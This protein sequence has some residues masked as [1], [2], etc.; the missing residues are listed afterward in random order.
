MEVERQKK[1]TNAT[2]QDYVKENSHYKIIENMLQHGPIPL[3]LIVS[4]LK[5]MGIHTVSGSTTSTSFQVQNHTKTMKM[6][7]QMRRLGFQVQALPGSETKMFCWN[8]KVESGISQ[9]DLKKKA[10]FFDGVCRRVEVATS[11]FFAQWATEK[12]SRK[13]EQK[14][15]VAGGKKKDSFKQTI[16]E[17]G[18]LKTSKSKQDNQRPIDKATR[19]AATSSPSTSS[20]PMSLPPPQNMVTNMMI[21]ITLQTRDKRTK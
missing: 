8:P 6:S 1:E 11:I 4:R 18:K 2:K 16:N 10:A 19:G 15:K 14:V 20:S 7:E 9:Q 3:H 5:F 12:K 13:Q 21:G 17:V